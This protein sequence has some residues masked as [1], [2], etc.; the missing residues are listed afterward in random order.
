MTVI[1][2]S[3]TTVQRDDAGPDPGSTLM[4]TGKMGASGS[5][6]PLNGIMLPW[7]SVLSMA[8]QT[9]GF[10]LRMGRLVYALFVQRDDAGP[11]PGSTLMGTGKMSASGST[12]P[13]TGIMLPWKS[14][15]SMALQRG[16]YALRMARLN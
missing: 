6:D 2:W 13:L 10:A 12:D 15:L 11:D 8:L 5:T 7:K 9:G 4:G 1:R 14:V 16:G 3:R